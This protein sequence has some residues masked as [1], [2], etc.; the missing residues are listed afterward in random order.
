MLHMVYKH[1][2]KAIDADKQ[3]IV[4]HADVKPVVNGALLHTNYILIHTTKK[5]QKSIIWLV[6]MTGEPIISSK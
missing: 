1:S 3:Q 5:H 2:S 6:L 4:L